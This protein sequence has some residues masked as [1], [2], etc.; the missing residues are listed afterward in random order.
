MRKPNQAI[1]R[2]RHLIPTVD[3]VNLKLTGADVFLKLDMPQAYH[4]LKLHKGSRYI[5]TFSTHVGLFRYKRLNHGTN[6]AAEIFQ[7]ALRTA[8][9][10]IPGV[11]NIADDIIVLVKIFQNMTRRSMTVFIGYHIKVLPL[12]RPSASF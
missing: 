10:G 8:L 9:K 6:A 4:Q 1:Q 3:D 5:T 12:M 2:I 11:C 7:N